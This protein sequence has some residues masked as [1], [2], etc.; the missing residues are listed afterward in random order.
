MNKRDLYITQVLNKAEAAAA[1]FSRFWAPWIQTCTRT[2]THARMPVP[3]TCKT[4]LNILLAPTFSEIN[5]KNLGKDADTRIH[6]TNSHRPCHFWHFPGK[7]AVSLRIWAILWDLR[8]SNTNSKVETQLH[9]IAAAKVWCSL[10]IPQRFQETSRP[11]ARAALPLSIQPLSWAPPGCWVS[12]FVPPSGSLAFNALA[13]ISGVGV[14]WEYS[15]Q[16]RRGGTMPLLLPSSHRCPFSH[17]KGVREQVPDEPHTHTDG[18]ILP[19]AWLYW[20]KKG[21][22]FGH[23]R[24]WIQDLNCAKSTTGIGLFLTFLA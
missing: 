14:A 6:R 22:C 4:T 18:E 2:W 8:Y 13:V 12:R 16:I 17:W 24:R 10:S 5:F 15:V 21:S 20:S 7:K 11:A 19:G 9:Q 23:L 3:F 1:R